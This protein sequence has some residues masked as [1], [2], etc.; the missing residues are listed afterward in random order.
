MASGRRRG[1]IGIGRQSGREERVCRSHEGG[2][3]GHVRLLK[4]FSKLQKGRAGM[5]RTSGS[6]TLSWRPEGAHEDPKAG[7]KLLAA[8]CR[9]A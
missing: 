9:V 3:A 1:L 6:W 4:N 8:K 5:W 7:E 2:P